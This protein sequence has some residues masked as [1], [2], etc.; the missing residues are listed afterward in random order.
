M[1]YA[2]F[3]I[4]GIAQADIVMSIYFS[5]TVEASRKASPVN[6]KCAQL[7]LFLQAQWNSKT[8]LCSS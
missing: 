2:V 5:F 1:V 4:M 6:P 3:C 7:T 8:H